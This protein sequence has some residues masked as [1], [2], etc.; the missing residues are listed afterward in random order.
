MRPLRP[1]PHQL[2]LRPPPRRPPP[3]PAQDE[4]RLRLRQWA[5]CDAEPASDACRVPPSPAQ[6][7]RQHELRLACRVAAHG[8]HLAHGAYLARGPPAARRARRALGALAPVSPASL[9]SRLWPP[10]PLT[11]HV[12]PA[13]ALGPR[14]AEGHRACVAPDV[15]PAR[16]GQPELQQVRCA[17][18]ASTD[19]QGAR[20]RDH[21]RRPARSVCIAECG[22][23]SLP[24]SGA[25]D[26]VRRSRT[27]TGLVS[28][29][30]WL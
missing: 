8:S 25:G 30:A 11:A 12:T 23:L 19:R 2:R 17:T 7:R 6:R 22:R 27:G 9:G 29:F 18:P 3:E 16:L 10:G 5:R 14:H 24:V 28:S 13:V 21:G 4:R 26:V 15:E 20:T 1:A